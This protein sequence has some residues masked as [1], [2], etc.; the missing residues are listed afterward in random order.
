MNIIC[1]GNALNR[2]IKIYSKEGFAIVSACRN[3]LSKEENILRTN[4][5]ETI[6]K[7]SGFSY[8]KINGGFIENKN[9]E[10]ETVV[11]EKSFI[12]FNNKNGEESKKNDLLKLALSICKK[13]NQE[14]VLYCE[15]NGNPRYYTKFGKVI[16]TFGKRFI[17][18]DNN[19]EYFS[20]FGKKDSNQK[21]TLDWQQKNKN[22]RAMQNKAK[23]IAKG[24]M[25]IVTEEN[26]YFNY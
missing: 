19:Q 25:S 17:F 13:F 14:S 23:N 15:K 3:E 10:N 12:I 16:S 5:L 26:N 4:E 2:F 1:E 22:D 9:L 8:K 6:I 21:V 24:K 20:E 18:N 11:R 7:N